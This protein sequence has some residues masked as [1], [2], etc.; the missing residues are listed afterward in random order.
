MMD[1]RAE[2]RAK[3]KKLYRLGKCR[4]CEVKDRRV[5]A[6]YCRACI[7]YFRLKKALAARKPL[8]TGA[9]RDAGT[10]QT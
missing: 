8:D 2:Q 10:P 6:A 4:R 5:D 9:T 3:H 7:T 1:I